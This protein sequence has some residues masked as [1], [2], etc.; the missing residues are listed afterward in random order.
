MY[1]NYYK[2]ASHFLSTFIFK[3]VLGG[4]KITVRGSTEK[5]ARYVLSNHQT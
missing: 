2:K 3:I 4:T 1:A 5:K